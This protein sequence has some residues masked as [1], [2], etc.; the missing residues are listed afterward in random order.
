MVV[1]YSEYKG[2]GVIYQIN[3]LVNCKKYIGQSWDIKRRIKD[4]QGTNGVKLVMAAMKKYGKDKFEFK[5]IFKTMDQTILN[6]AEILAIRLLNTADENYG[7]NIS[8]GGSNG[9]LNESTKKLLS[10][11]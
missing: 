1:N 6:N 5:I 11:R 9:K 10:E 4:H 2:T 7:Y 8:L 3:N